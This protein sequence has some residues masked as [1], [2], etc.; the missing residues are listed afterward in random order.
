LTTEGIVA[1]ANA[2][3]I[4]V[5]WNEPIELAHSSRILPSRVSRIRDQPYHA[6]QS[7]HGAAYIDQM[8]DRPDC[9]SK[10]LM[11]K[12]YEMPN[13][14]HFSIAETGGLQGQLP[15]AAS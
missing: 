12:T 4:V 11:G 10:S 7:P 1:L 8:L 5:S 3:H 9:S 13:S 14:Y 2:E 6:L 15:A